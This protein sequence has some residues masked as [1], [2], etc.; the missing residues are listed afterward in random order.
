MITALGEGLGM[1]LDETEPGGAGVAR[2]LSGCPS[3]VT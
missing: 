3:P 1:G 2:S